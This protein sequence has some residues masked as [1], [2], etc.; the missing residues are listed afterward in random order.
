V[1]L[2]AGTLIRGR[3][4]SDSAVGAASI[5]GALL[6][7]AA[8]SML[9]V[10]SV[11]AGI[12]LT[13]WTFA[14]WFLRLLSNATSEEARVPRP[15]ARPAAAWAAVWVVVVAYAAG[16]LYLGHRTFSV[17]GRAQRF[18]WNYNYGFYAPEPG[19]EPPYRWTK[20]TAVTVVPVGGRSFNLK[21]WTQDPTAAQRPVLAKV[22]VDDRLV[23]DAMLTSSRPV[24]RRIDVRDG[25]ARMVVRTW[26][27]RTFSPGVQ[28]S[29]D[30]RE[31]GLAV[32]DWTFGH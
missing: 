31:L 17:P 12:T 27:D 14:F 32:G 28:G 6:G 2:F 23:L 1:L 29:P 25:E 10:P 16:T 3:V 19:A 20:R 11:S 18:G 8:A 13:F 4:E 15:L 30:P 9:G 26:V 22:W 5:K 24:Q 21:V 7:L